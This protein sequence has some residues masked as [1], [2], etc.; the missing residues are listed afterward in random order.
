[1]LVLWRWLWMDIPL[2]HYISTDSTHTYLHSFFLFTRNFNVIFNWILL[3]YLG[4][5]CS[6]THM[7]MHTHAHACNTLHTTHYVLYTLYYLLLGYCEQKLNVLKKE[8]LILA[9][10]FQDTSVY[11]GGKLYITGAYNKNS[12]YHWAARKS[13]VGLL[14]STFC[15]WWL[16]STSQASPPRVSKLLKTLGNKLSKQEPLDPQT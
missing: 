13:E 3:K 16:I 10:G 5:T 9:L 1:M 2:V 11:H 7:C 15:P 4:N 14:S 12:S 6:W 8:W